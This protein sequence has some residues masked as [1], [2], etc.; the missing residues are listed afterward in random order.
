[1]AKEVMQRIIIQLKV[2]HVTQPNLG[3]FNQY[4]IAARYNGSS[5]KKVYII[6]FKSKQPFVYNFY[7]KNNRMDKQFTTSYDICH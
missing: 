5:V 6:Q 1:M 3:N 4:F 2:I 7:I